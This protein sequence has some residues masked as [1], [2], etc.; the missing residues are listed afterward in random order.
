MASAA[1]S[2]VDSRTKWEKP[3]M[4]NSPL[5]EAMRWEHLYYQKVTDVKVSIDVCITGFGRTDFIYQRSWR[6]STPLNPT[7]ALAGSVAAA[8]NPKADFLRGSIS[9][10]YQVVIRFFQ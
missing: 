1:S 5:L 9:V 4:R 10:L 6:M 7:S 8:G 2:T 3:L